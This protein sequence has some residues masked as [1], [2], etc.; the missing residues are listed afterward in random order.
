MPR[1][2]TTNTTSLWLPGKFTELT[3]QQQALYLMLKGQREITAAGTLPLTVQRWTKT[4]KGWTRQL[5]DAELS[6]LEAAGHLVIDRDTEE[7]LLVKFV[8]FDGGYRN[9]KRRPVIAEAALAIMSPT[10]RTALAD[11]LAELDA[12]SDVVSRLRGDAL[13]GDAGDKASDRESGFDRVVVNQGES[14]PQPTT[15]NQQPVAPAGK[16]PKREIPKSLEAAFDEFWSIYPLRKGKLDAERKFAQAAK[17]ADPGVILAGARRFAAAN[18][19][20]E[21]RFIAH[22][23][24]WLHQGRWDD[25]APTPKPRAV[26]DFGPEINTWT[27]EDA[28]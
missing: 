4:A 14:V 12:L 20:T 23:A 19:Q 18:R 28:S 5:I 7:V 17:R 24:T 9:E 11:E 27:P 3:P 25:D 10:L 16:P 1:N 21:P 15:H 2:Y 8:K 26:G 22:P 13:S 6:A